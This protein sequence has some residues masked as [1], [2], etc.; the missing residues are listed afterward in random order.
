MR[1][2]L[3]YAVPILILLIFMLIMHS[4]LF[5][6]EP[7]NQTDDFADYLDAVQDHVMAEQWAQAAANLRHLKNAWR[8][9]INRVQFSVEKDE[10][11]R[12]SANLAR[13]GGAITAQDQGG[14]MVEIG[15]AREFW[16][17]LGR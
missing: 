5:L 17:E 1:K 6:K 15:E 9:I 12:L 14:A 10:I 8:Q 13:M 16:Y 4:G 11:T 7:L 2:I 3:A